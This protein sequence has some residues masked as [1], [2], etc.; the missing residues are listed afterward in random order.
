M[1][2]FYQNSETYSLLADMFLN[3]K[4][5][6]FSLLPQEL[7]L[8]ILKIFFD[9]FSILYER[10]SKNIKLYRNIRIGKN[11]RSIHQMMTF[12][13][14]KCGLDFGVNNY[15]I[16]LNGKILDNNQVLKICSSCNCCDRH[17]QNRPTKLDYWTDTPFHGTQIT[18]DD[19]QCTCRHISRF[20]CREITPDDY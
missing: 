17:Q 5:L 16:H 4:N 12:A 1:D 20:I 15:K 6:Y 7:T 8:N 3:D 2:T 19:C 14:F 13:R 10:F 11:V 18:D 9:N